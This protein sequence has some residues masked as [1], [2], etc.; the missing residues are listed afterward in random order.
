MAHK[1]YFI[2]HDKL[3]MWP[4]K[5]KS[6]NIHN[7]AFAQKACG[8]IEYVDNVVTIA[9]NIGRCRMFMFKNTSKCSHTMV[10]LAGRAFSINKT[11]AVL[12]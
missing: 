5:L 4:I 11:Q 8:H 7:I 9:E 3:E 12:D 6:K 10:I 2:I 1:Q